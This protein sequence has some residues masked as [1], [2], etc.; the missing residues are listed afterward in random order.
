V[1]GVTKVEPQATSK[2]K[3][4]ATRDASADLAAAVMNAQG[5]LI[6]LAVEEPSLDA[7]YTRYFEEQARA[8]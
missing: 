8:A 7:I 3:V 4:H 6:R 1:A 5:R 2:Y